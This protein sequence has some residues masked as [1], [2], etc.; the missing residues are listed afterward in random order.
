M[1]YGIELVTT[2]TNAEGKE[3]I[4]FCRTNGSN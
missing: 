2:F 3:H 1:Q 4:L